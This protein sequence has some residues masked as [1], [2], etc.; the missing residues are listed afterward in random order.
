MLHDVPFSTLA[1]IPSGPLLLD[2]LRFCRRVKTAWPD[3]KLCR[4]ISCLFK[5]YFVNSVVS[6]NS[7]FHLC[8]RQLRN[9]HFEV[10]INCSSLS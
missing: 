8:R 4:D 1:E 5:E 2:T 7:L 6:E 9:N 10:T 3:T